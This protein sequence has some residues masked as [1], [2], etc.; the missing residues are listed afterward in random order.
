LTFW[1][2]AT[3]IDALVALVCGSGVAEVFT[4]ANA[5]AAPV[6]RLA[7]SASLAL[8]VAVTAGVTTSLLRRP[9]PMRG[10]RVFFDRVAHGYGDVLNPDR[11]A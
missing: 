9:D 4:G 2:R 6:E 11:S 3:A 1:P 8:V 7:A 10:G 5:A